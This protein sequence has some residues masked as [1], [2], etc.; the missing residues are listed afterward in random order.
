MWLS[1]QIEKN[2]QNELTPLYSVTILYDIKVE[3]LK[4]YLIYHSIL[5]QWIAFIP[6]SDQSIIV[7]LKVINRLLLNGLTV[8]S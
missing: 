4:S 1:Y 6:K 8:I 5:Y 3:Y 2:K 7:I